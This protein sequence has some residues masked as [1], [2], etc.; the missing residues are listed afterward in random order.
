[1]APKKKA[2]APKNPKAAKAAKV[3]TPTRAPEPYIPP[4]IPD[5]LRH[6]LSTA[7]TGMQLALVVGA[8]RHAVFTKSRL[9]RRVHTLEFDVR[10]CSDRRVCWCRPFPMDAKSLEVTDSVEAAV[11][12]SGSFGYVFAVHNTLANKNYAL[13]VI[14][15]KAL[16]AEHGMLDNSKM[17]QEVQTLAELRHGYIAQYFNAV[18]LGGGDGATSRGSLK[19]WLLIQLE[20][21][22]GGTLQ[23]QLDECRTEN[24]GSG[25]GLPIA[26]VRTH[27]AQLA[28]AFTFLAEKEIVHRDLKLD[29]VCLSAAG[30]DCRVVDLGLARMF[31]GERQSSQAHHNSTL[32]KPRGNKHYQS[33][34][35]DGRHRIDHKDDMWALG[36][37]LCE[38]ITGTTV[39][40]LL[41]PDYYGKVWQGTYKRK[42]AP[43]IKN[44]KARDENLGCIAE[45]LLNSLPDE[46]YGAVDVAAQL[47]KAATDMR[48]ISDDLPPFVPVVGRCRLTL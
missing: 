28:E 10:T 35:N 40:D 6:L 29:N 21:C 27:L 26:D 45:G 38:M 19:D 17:V 14:N 23:R 46:R 12:G 1:M 2:D 37:M 22:T 25:G 3:D 33:P 20:L 30:G 42:L 36:L 7:L 47:R 9:R 16:R 34:E 44:A 41:G 39:A 5:Q 15:M 24:G 43:W 48:M 4:D 32:L 11:L 31:G 13:K 8:R 18:E